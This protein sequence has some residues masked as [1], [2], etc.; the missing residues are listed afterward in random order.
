MFSTGFSSNIDVIC[1]ARR[2][3][4]ILGWMQQEALNAGAM[5]AGS[6]AIEENGARYNRFYWIGN[7]G[8]RGYYDKNY[9]FMLSEEP[10]YFKAGT[11]KK[12][13]L[14]RGWKIKPIVCY[15]L[16]FPELSRNSSADP[17]DILV[18]AASWPSVRSDVW[19][20]LLKARAIENQCY[21]IGIN[22]VGV[23]ANGLEHAGDSIVYSPKGQTIIKIPENEEKIVTVELS[24]S[25]LNN[26][27]KK[28]PVLED[29][30]I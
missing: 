22:R 14:W 15:D 11:E 20:T 2:K 1:T 23:D 25:E 18:C 3:A 16:R 5:L 19:L 29:I 17:Y 28:F 27:R 10:A 9:L 7:D 21:A 4:L 8:T 24:F 6:V 30:K 12:Q 13:F 26:F